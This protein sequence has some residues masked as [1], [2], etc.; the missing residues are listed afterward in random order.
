LW[1][2][3]TGKSAADVEW[4]ED[5]ARLKHSCC[6]VRMCALRGFPPPDEQALAKKLKV[7]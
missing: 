3:L 7:N 2:E 4:F 5:F 1:E 6:H